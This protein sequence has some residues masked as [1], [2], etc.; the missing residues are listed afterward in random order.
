MCLNPSTL[1]NGQGIACRICWQCI[2]RKILDWTGRCIAESKTSF[3]SNYITLTY[4]RDDDGNED[5][6]RAKVLT[7]S[8]VQKY[9]KKLRF[10]GFPLRYFVAG[11][12]GPTKGRTHWHLIVFWQ[13]A[14]PKHKKNKMFNEAHWEHGHSYWEDIGPNAVRYCCKYLHK[15]SEKEEKQSHTSMSKI[16]PLGGKYF[17]QLAQVYVDQGLAP[18]DLKYSFPESRNFQ[19]GKKYQYTMMDTSAE[20]FMQVYLRKWEAKYPGVLHPFSQILDDYEDSLLE[21][22]LEIKKEPRAIRIRYPRTDDLKRGMKMSNIYYD[23]KLH[24]L[25]HAF[26]FNQTPWYWVFNEKGKPHWVN[27]LKE[28]V[29]PSQW[30]TDD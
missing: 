17:D 23:E 10:N 11:E 5:H 2:E 26:E 19:T 12:Y 29:P 1:S 15:D 4:G 30:R 20:N 7:Y 16:P 24:V 21:E 22:D 13:S 8:D 27:D 25:C 6:L 28:A 9:F 14:V 18:Q 3:A